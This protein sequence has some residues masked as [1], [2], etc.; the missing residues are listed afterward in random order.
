MLQSASSFLPCMALAP[1]D[2]ERILDVAAAPGR[3]VIEI[4]HSTDVESTS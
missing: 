3:G 4:K 1:Q 2:G